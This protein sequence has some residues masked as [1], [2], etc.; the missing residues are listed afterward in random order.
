MRA[1]V[2]GILGNEVRIREKR[3]TRMLKRSGQYSSYLSRTFI[4][5]SSGGCCRCYLQTL[6]S[7]IVQY[8]RK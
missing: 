3:P 6:K 2:Q 1:Y 8:L 7:R 4:E 5:T